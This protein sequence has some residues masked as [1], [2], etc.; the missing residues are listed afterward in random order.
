MSEVAAPITNEAPASPT[1]VDGGLTA[2]SNLIADSKTE[3]PSTEIKS[4]EV[5][6]KPDGEVKLDDKPIEYTDFTLPEGVKFDEKLLTDFKALATEAKLPQEQAQK[7]IDLHAGTMKEAAEA[8]YRQWADTQKQW[9]KQV[10][11]DPEIGGEKLEAAKATIAK[12]L[13]TI[14]GAEA[15][16][17]R[18]AFNFTGA[19]N[20]PEI[21]RMM[22]RLSQ[23]VTEGS[24]VQGNAPGGKG[25]SAAETI[26]P[27]QKGLGNE[28]N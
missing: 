24:I 7:L 5:E 16:K 2:P 3:Q 27:T 9:Q 8:P 1:P 14:G 18:E 23:A 26:Y 15:Q 19:G 10:M 17:I 28:S 25:K 4:S 12:A 20:N 6:T 22:Y 21:F 11:S 13:D